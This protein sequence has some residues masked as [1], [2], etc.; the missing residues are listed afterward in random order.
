MKNLSSQTTRLA[1]ALACLALS[2]ATAQA[3]VKVTVSKMHI[4]CKGCTM[5][6]QKAVADIPEV[7][8]TVD[9]ENT[10][11]VLVAEKAESV[12]KAIDAIA[13]AGFHGK[14]DNKEV[15]FK[16]EKT[17]EGKVQRLEVYSVHNCCPACV[18]AIK[19]ALAKVDGVT[20]DT[21]ENKKDSFVIEGDFAAKDALAA[22]HKAGF[23]ASL[24]K[25]EPKS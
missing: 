17:P 3:E 5:A 6:I 21:C 11:T 18:K 20:A 9:Q 7:K 10:S 22:L 19:T 13:K 4:C 2:A 16:E 12:Q 23:H 15:K 14:L 1:A 8:A 24:T 25:P